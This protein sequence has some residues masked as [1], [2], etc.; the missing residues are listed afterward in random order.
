MEEIEGVK[1]LLHSLNR[2][3]CN[4]SVCHTPP[5]DCEAVASTTEVLKC[6]TELIFFISF[7]FSLQISKDQFDEEFI[8]A[9]GHAADSCDEQV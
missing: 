5:Q 9:E 6:V 8:G 3:D 4:F 1:F 7:L 2:G